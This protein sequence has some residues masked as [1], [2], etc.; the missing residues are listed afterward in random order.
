MVFG[1]DVERILSTLGDD[2]TTPDDDDSTVAFDGPTRFQNS[3]KV[4]AVSV[5]YV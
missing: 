1:G 2:D 3:P 5:W 4:P